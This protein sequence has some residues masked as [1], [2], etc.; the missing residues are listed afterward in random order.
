MTNSTTSLEK[1]SLQLGF[2]P[3]TDCAPLVIGKEKGFFEKH[4][5][6]VTLSRE[7]SWANIRDKVAI[8]ILDGA[9]MLAPMPLAMSLG[10]SPIH[11]PM[12]TAFSMGLNGNAITV[13]TDLHQKMT[14]IDPES[15][16]N[17]STNVY[18]LKAVIDDNK[19]RGLD[20]FTF[21]VVY[22]FSPHNYEL[23]YWM[24][25]A[26]ID[27]DKD[28]RLV[29]VPPPQMV[30]QLEQGDIDG[31][32]VGEPWNTLAVQQGIGRT[33]IT[34]YEI[35][36]NSPE[37]VLGVSEEWSSQYPETHKA[38]V[39]A[40][41]EASQWV[42]EESNRKEVAALISQRMYINAPEHAV[43][44]SMTGSYQYSVDSMPEAL[45]DFN[46]FHRYAANY[47]WRSHAEWFLLQMLRWDHIQ[48]PVDVHDIANKVY[49]PDLF[50]KAANELGL[51]TPE[52]DRKS[53]GLNKSERID[54]GISLG[55]DLFFDKKHYHPGKFAE[56]LAAF[57]I[58]QSKKYT[59]LLVEPVHTEST[60]LNS[61][62]PP[63]H[64]AG[65]NI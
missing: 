14:R 37:K 22:P 26:G 59:D 52:H 51:S 16:N 48:E 35:W 39:K 57:E 41:I 13:S 65:R 46:V 2:I 54:D 50:V 61:S 20:P 25:S 6:D 36:N 3:L 40:L 11:K 33:L 10:L 58:P 38:L 55:A 7:T 27:P 42:D 53:E 34:K 21:A 9:Q 8:G 1:N 49:R 18:A 44:T 28:I 45:P 17:R 19:S 5:L 60:N 4:G 15:M 64:S 23:R 30:G 43:R 56:Y 47:P 62:N 29:V 63:S 31:Y 24:A 12:V 32:C